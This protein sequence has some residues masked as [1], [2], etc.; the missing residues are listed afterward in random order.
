MIEG[1]W[2]SCMCED[3]RG[4]QF[5]LY[6]PSGFR[7]VVDAVGGALR[8]ISTHCVMLLVRSVAEG[9]GGVEDTRVSLLGRRWWGGGVGGVDRSNTVG[10]KR[11]VII[12]THPEVAHG[13]NVLLSFPR[14][15]FCA[16]LSP[17]CREIGV[18]VCQ[19][20]LFGDGARGDNANIGG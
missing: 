9:P 4:V 5:G 14:V 10:T 12:H 7:P 6:A 19:E 13:K 11:H 20:C 17:C 15:C 1:P 16:T 8:L 18:I 2:G 3:V